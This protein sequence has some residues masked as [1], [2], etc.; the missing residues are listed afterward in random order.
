M[1]IRIVDA[2]F[3]VFKRYGEHIRFDIERFEEI[4]N[5]HAPYLMDESYLIVLGMKIGLFEAL[6]FDE[7]IDYQS[8]VNN[9]KLF[10]KLSEE[11]ALFM[12]AALKQLVD[13]IG[14]H[15]ELP[16]FKELLQLAYKR[17]N[18]EQLYAIGKS[19]FL[20]FG[21][22]QDYIAAFEIFDYL[23]HL[24]HRL[25]AYYLGYMYEHGDGIEK[26]VRKAMAYYLYCGDDRSYYRLG[27]IYLQGKDVSPDEEMA[28]DYFQ[29]SCDKDSYL[30]EGLL[31]SQQKLYAKA[32]EAFYCGALLF[33]KDCLY[34]SGLYLKEG[35]GTE[36]DHKKAY[37]F[38]MYAYYLGSGVAAFELGMMLIIGM[39]VN[40]DREKGV[41]FLQQATQLGSY[42][43]CI[44]LAKLYESGEFVS[45]D[46]QKALNYLK[47]AMSMN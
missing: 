11:E 39:G 2:V 3:N 8:Y 21:T 42:W 41:D 27:L 45:Q 12:V 40:Q 9:V 15:F 36:V 30:Y 14:Y 1:D 28:L 16:N 10:L 33:Q 34:Y 32:F 47:K 35:L 20:G 7:N 19:Y 31:L 26:D 18:Q 29:R 37:C 6:I 43:A 13:R 5:D 25:S 46:K 17:N 4:L 24:G 44:M 23:Y 22:A 38:F